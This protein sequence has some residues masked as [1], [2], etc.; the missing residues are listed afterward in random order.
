M[1]VWLY[2][3][4]MC[5]FHNVFLYCT[6]LY[7]CMYVCMYA[8]KVGLW[9]GQVQGP[10]EEEEGHGAPQE[11]REDVSSS[12]RRRPG[13]V[14]PPPRALLKCMYT[15]LYCMYVCKYYTKLYVC[16][17][18]YLYPYIYL[19]TLRL[20]LLL[21]IYVCIC[22]YHVYFPYTFMYVCMFRVYKLTNVCMRRCFYQYLW[23]F[24]RYLP[25]Y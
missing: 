1:Y 11:P 20:L 23:S 8:G 22:M 6:V 12:L 2:I 13:A 21:L 25:T 16:M 10:R 19:D 9:G 15:I 18:A 24:C 4:L 3:F 7:V 14:Q 17:Y 5:G